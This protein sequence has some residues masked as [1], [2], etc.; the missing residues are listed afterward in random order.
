MNNCRI[1]NQ[2]SNQIKNR[3]ENRKNIKQD[4]SPSNVVHCKNKLIQN[5]VAFVPKR[6][7]R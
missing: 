2:I 5:I 7:T 3:K 6:H 4:N 1:N